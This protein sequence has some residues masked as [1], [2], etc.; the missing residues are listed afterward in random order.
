MKTTL[1]LIRHGDP[2]LP[3]ERVFY[4]S[5]DLP[6]SGEGERKARALRPFLEALKPDRV[7]SSPLLRC[8]ETAR[9]AGMSPA[10]P[11]TTIKN[12]SELNMGDWEMTTMDHV[13]SL[14]PGILKDRWEKLETF[15]PPSGE[16]FQD[17]ADRV[18]PAIRELAREGGVTAVFGH[19]GVFMTVLW[20]ELRIPLKTVFSIRQSYC[21]IHVM[22]YGA[23]V[24]LV[25]GNWSPSVLN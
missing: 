10:Y 24:E 18:V 20:K 23:T 8:Q 25:K 17:L 3:K 2:E 19:S 9:E 1:F 11:V 7:V 21:G 4:G 14:N 5:T 13:D 15:R 6:L 22:S 12:L 16:S